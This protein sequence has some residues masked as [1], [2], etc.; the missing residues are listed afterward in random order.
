M[1]KTPLYQKHVGLQARMIEFGQWLMPVE[2]S[3]ILNEHRTTRSAAGIFDLTHMGELKVEGEK[4]LDLVQKLV[5]ND[6][7]ALNINQILY[8]TVCKEDGGILDD[9]LVYRLKD[10][11]FLVVNASNVDKIYNWFK[12][13]EVFETKVSNV[14]DE[15]VLIA[16]QGP[17]SE[18]ILQSQIDFNLSGIKYY[19]CEI[20]KVGGCRCMVSRTGYTGEDG[21]EIYCSP[22]EGGYIW[23]KLMDAGRT[24]GIVP[25]GLGARDTLRLEAKYCLY[26]HEINEKIN[27]IEAGLKWVV[28]FDKGDFIG[29]DVLERFRK[30]RELVGFEILEKGI[31]RQGYKITKDNKE[32]GFVTSGTFSPTLNKS[33]GLGYVLSEYKDIGTR[34]EIVIREKKVK[35]EI[36]KTPFYKGSIKSGRDL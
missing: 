8:T 35:A 31:P 2:Y 18:K 12:S 26:G 30:T 3:G 14:S 36:I 27:P 13:H 1:K 20:V 16:I 21:F 9:I 23:D 29:R 7:G 5:T 24:Y 28:K 10:Y 17:E 11:I 25:V 22:L 6:V 32:I 4:R 34:F 15:N 19:H 33:I